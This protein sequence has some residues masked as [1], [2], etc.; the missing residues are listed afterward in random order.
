MLS[1]AQP[2]YYLLVNSYIRLTIWSLTLQTG[3]IYLQCIL[4]LSNDKKF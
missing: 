4:H 3:Y 2:T 1:V